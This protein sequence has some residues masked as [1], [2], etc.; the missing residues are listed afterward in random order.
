MTLLNIVALFIPLISATRNHLLI[1]KKESLSNSILAFWGK[2]LR[3][4]LAW[5]SL[6]MESPIL[7]WKSLIFWHF[8]IFLYV[9]VFISKKVLFLN[10]TLKVSQKIKKKL[11]MSFIYTLLS[12]KKRNFRKQRETVT[13][14]SET[15]ENSQ[16]PR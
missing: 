6:Q 8:Y 2:Y 14:Q 9:P 15:L 1:K 3:S 5:H 16:N 13:L 7:V 10:K 12:N 4:F 11:K